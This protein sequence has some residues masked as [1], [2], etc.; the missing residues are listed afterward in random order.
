M[1]NASFHSSL[2]IDL[3]TYPFAENASNEPLTFLLVIPNDREES[4]RIGLASPVGRDLLRQS[5]SPRVSAPLRC[6]R[7]DISGDFGGL[8]TFSA[9]GVGS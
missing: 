6:A 2:S 5:A 9:K 8:D 3:A 4:R 7:N 1:V